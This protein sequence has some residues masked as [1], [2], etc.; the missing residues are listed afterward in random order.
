MSGCNPAS[1][2]LQAGQAPQGF[3]APVHSIARAN[4]PAAVRLPVPRPPV[5]KRA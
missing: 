4:H 1:A 2:F 5:N 3:S